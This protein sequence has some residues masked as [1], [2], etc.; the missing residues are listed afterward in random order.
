[1]E[2][3]SG[4]YTITNLVNNKIYAGQ[5]INVLL[6]LQQH[7]TNLISNIHSN[8][9]LQNSFNKHGI[10]NFKFEILEECSQEYLCSQENYW[11]NLLYVH[12]DKFGYNIKPTH[13]EGKTI[14]SIE[15]KI[16]IGITHRKLHKSG[17]IKSW[18][19]GK[20]FTEKHKERLRASNVGQKR[21]EEAKLKMSKSMKGRVFTEETLNK[22]RLAKK[23]F[24]VT[25]GNKISIQ[26]LQDLRI[27]RVIVLQY[28]LNENFIKEWASL[29]LVERVL[30]I[31]NANLHKCCSK[32]KLRNNKYLTLKGFIWKFK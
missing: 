21:T 19:K 23:D 12:N 14:Q 32:N 10:E 17:I 15:T 26:K 11:C 13:P 31:N 7:K 4:I 29:L 5:S 22:F 25:W 2:I 9:F 3:I 6:R 1:M 30:K 24:K 18:A 27:K 28:D 8:K 20:H 16:K